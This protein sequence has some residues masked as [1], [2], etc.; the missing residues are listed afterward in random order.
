MGPINLE[1]RKPLKVMKLLNFL[2]EDDEVAHVFKAWKNK[3]SI[4]PSWRFYPGTLEWYP[5]PCFGGLTPIY[6]HFNNIFRDF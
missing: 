2:A 1:L 5:N 4:S 6:P 3:T